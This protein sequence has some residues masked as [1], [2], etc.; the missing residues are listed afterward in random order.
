M[1]YVVP[2]MPQTF[3][4]GLAMRAAMV[5]GALAR[6]FDVHLFV[7]PVT[8]D[9]GP[10]SDFVRSST[11]RIGGL[12]LARNVDP[13]YGLI[14]R[15]LDPD[16]RA[17]AELAY[18]KPYLSRFCT[19]DSAG[20]LLEWGSQFSVSAVHVMRL[21][22]APLAF[23]FLRRSPADR[24]L[25]VLDLDEDDVQTCCRLA[26]LYSELGD[27]GAA[28][29]ATA[30]AKKYRTFTDRY[31]GAFDRVIVSSE[32]DAVRLAG[33]FPGARF[34][35]VPNAYRPVELIHRRRR[36]GRRPGPLRLIFVGT[37]GY[38]PN[39]DAARFLCREVLPILR[40]LSDREIRIDLVGSGSTAAMAGF[41]GRSE[42]EVH[43]FA[44]NLAPLYAAADVA[45]VPVRAGGGTRIKILEAFAHGVPV[46]TTALGA[47]GID[48]D[49]GV[50][51][52]FADDAE[53]F[54]RA[55]LR[56]KEVPELAA[57]LVAHAAELLA[58]RY[59]PARVDAALAEAY[60]DPA[61]PGRNV[62]RLDP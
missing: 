20:Y 1:L 16:A 61:P 31:L 57:R 38:F 51:L 41:A 11:V 32:P 14:A 12:D 13:L 34:A 21:Y 3:G 37:F 29:F 25:C 55:C 60:G 39:L 27:R 23:P 49:D 36:R 62:S 53:A 15:V 54:A 59:T 56:L 4:N 35:L 2:V 7:V 17:R 47:E 43:G 50:H 8:G 48:A 6:R 9:V 28:A 58:T 33:R 5:L 52:L 24:P 42:V 46:V 30:E 10:P 26:R 40:R 22:L 45:A 19:G 18:P 44:E